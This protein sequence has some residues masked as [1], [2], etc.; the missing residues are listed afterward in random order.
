MYNSTIAQTIDR[1]AG[2]LQQAECPTPHADA[3]ALIAAALKI[4]ADALDVEAGEHVSESAESVIE[5]YIKRR[6][7]REPLAYILGQVTFCDLALMIDQRVLVPSPQSQMLVDVATVLKPGSTVHDVGTGSGAIALAIKDRRPDLIVTG[8][9]LS[10]A[11]IAVARENASR[12]KLDVP[13]NVG[14][15]V[16]E[17]QFDLVV[18]NLPYADIEMEV[19]PESALYEPHVAVYSGGDGDGLAVIRALVQSL[20][21]GTFL[22]LQHAPSQI[23][24]VRAFFEDPDTLG[25][26]DPFARV[27]AGLLR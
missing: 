23:K 5:Q 11:A 26:D 22:A 10:P 27:T 2:R 21:S 17:G 1:E 19:S 13:F 9:D 4:E 20:D 18:A 14:A 7:A 25:G 3:K 15:F 8:S 6:A 16:P 24:D 12:L